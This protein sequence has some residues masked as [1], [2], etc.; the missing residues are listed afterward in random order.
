VIPEDNCPNETPTSKPY[1]RSNLK[2]LKPIKLSNL[3]NLSILIYDA[4][5]TH[6]K[7]T[8][9]YHFRNEYFTN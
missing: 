9:K 3:R 5:I 7:Q 6:F 2:T 8:N 1:Q 4:K